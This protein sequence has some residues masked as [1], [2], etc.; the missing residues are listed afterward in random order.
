MKK[1]RI[2]LLRSA[3]VSA[4]LCVAALGT[5]GPRVSPSL[6]WAS[7]PA[8]VL[9]E[10][11]PNCRSATTEIVGVTDRTARYTHATFDFDAPPSKAV[12][13]RLQSDLYQAS[14]TLLRGVVKV[15]YLVKGMPP[16]P[17]ASAPVVR[18]VPVVGAKR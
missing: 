16:P 12:A 10:K 2:S 7:H 17:Q 13:S 6:H 14:P 15:D 5:Y 11:T 3:L 4:G 1:P 9:C 8:T 18:Q